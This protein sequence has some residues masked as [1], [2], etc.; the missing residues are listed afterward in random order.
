MGT[1]VD[2]DEFD[3]GHLFQTWFRAL[4]VPEE[5]MQYDNGGQ[6]LPVAREDCSPI[7]ELL[8]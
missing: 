8:A 7:Q 2:G 4:G 1:F 6:P 5:K 3:I